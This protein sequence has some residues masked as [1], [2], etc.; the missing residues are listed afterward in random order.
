MRLFPAGFDS[1]LDG[2]HRGAVTM[3][4]QI[5]VCI[6]GPEQGVRYGFFIDPTTLN[7]SSETEGQGIER[8]ISLAAW[9]GTEFDG[10]ALECCCRISLAARTA[11]RSR[12][13]HCCVHTR[14]SRLR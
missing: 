2:F 1:A 6:A 10:R 8:L 13:Q 5:P 11:I 9:G 3:L 14:G 12:C 4:A 7:H